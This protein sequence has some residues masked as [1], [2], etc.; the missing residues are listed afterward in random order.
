MAKIET[1]TSSA[2]QRWRTPPALWQP[3][4]E[5]FGGFVFDA[6]AERVSCVVA[7]ADGAPLPFFGPDHPLPRM[8][9]C[10]TADW[11]EAIGVQMLARSR[12]LPGYGLGSAQPAVWMNSPYGYQIGKFVARASLQS[13]RIGITTLCL[14]NAKTDTNW[15]LDEVVRCADEIRFYHGRVCFLDADTGLPPVSVDEDGNETTTGQTVG[16]ALIV[17]R[18]WIPR[19]G[20]RHVYVDVPPGA[21]ASAFRK[22]VTADE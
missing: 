10:L 13:R 11:A 22:G 17:F 4:A 7:P 12:S 2:S 1:L 16:S 6:C 5:E 20:P 3:L 14:V 21:R 8:R 19:G 15:W 9:D 18:P